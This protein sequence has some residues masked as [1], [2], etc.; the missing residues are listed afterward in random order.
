MGGPGDVS[1]ELSSSKRGHQP[2]LSPCQVTA[3]DLRG[4]LQGFS[5][6]WGVSG[7]LSWREGAGGSEAQEGSY[8]RCV[9]ACPAA[10][11]AWR[12][13]GIR[14]HR[15]HRPKIITNISECLLSAQFSSLE[16]GPTHPLGSLQERTGASILSRS[17]ISGQTRR[18]PP[19]AHPG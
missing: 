14:F 3:S 2:S 13:N 18:G 5:S 15:H 17:D 10:I 19:Q 4:L 12:A 7:Q 11:R 1:Q 9:Q 6:G 16:T 8:S